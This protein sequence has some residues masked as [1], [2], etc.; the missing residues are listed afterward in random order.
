MNL[1]LTQDSWTIRDYANAIFIYNAANFL[2]QN[3]LK[4]KGKK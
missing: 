3:G 1:F 4:Q 2:R